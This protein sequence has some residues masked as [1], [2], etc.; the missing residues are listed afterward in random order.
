[1]CVYIY[2]YT[3]PYVTRGPRLLQQHAQAIITIDRI[4]IITIDRI[5]IIIVNRIGFLELLLCLG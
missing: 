1:M 2:I 4:Y 5:A 3:R